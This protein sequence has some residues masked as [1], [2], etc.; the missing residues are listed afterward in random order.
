M[1]VSL[2]SLRASDAPPS[3]EAPSAGGS[4]FP[5]VCVAPVEV[6]SQRPVAVLEDEPARWFGAGGLAVRPPL[7]R[8][9][10]GSCR[11]G[12]APAMAGG[13][14]RRTV[15]SHQEHEVRCPQAIPYWRTSPTG[16]SGCRTPE[17]A[18]T[19]AI[20]DLRRVGGL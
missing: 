2:Y 4:V 3:G 12:V 19:L 1:V 17:L 7:E 13:A 14:A 15:M 8:A 11:G 10:F 16:G 6:P 20:H 9:D 5:E 18:L